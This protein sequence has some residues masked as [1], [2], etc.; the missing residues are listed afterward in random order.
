MTMT[1]KRLISKVKTNDGLLGKPATIGIDAVYE[2]LRSGDYAERVKKIVAQA[3]A[4]V[5][6]GVR[7]EGQVTGV[8]ALPYLLFSATFG[9]VTLKR[10]GFRNGSFK[11]QR[12]WYVKKREA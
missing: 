12:G 10:C 2:K 1:N 11:G 7:H 8:D 3:T 5:L 9:N 4:A 6:D